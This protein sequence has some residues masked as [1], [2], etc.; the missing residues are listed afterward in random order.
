MDHFTE[1]R[2]KHAEEVISYLPDTI[3][4]A[5]N[6]NNALNKD[7]IRELRQTI[8]SMRVTKEGRPQ[9]AYRKFI[10]LGNKLLKIAFAHVREKGLPLCEGGPGCNACCRRM[11]IITSKLEEDV[12]TR[13]IKKMSTDERRILVKG[14][15]RNEKIMRGVFLAYGVKGAD[16]P[17]NVI[18][19]VCL[20]F[21]EV[22]G[23]CPALG[24]TGRCLIYPVRP[25]ICRTYRVLGEECRPL[26]R[27]NVTR[28]PDIDATMLSLL[29][30]NRGKT[31]TTLFPVIRESLRPPRP[32]LAIV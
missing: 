27:L 31:K 6:F 16:L 21:A 17:T 24:P 22:G 1:T 25:W 30:R 12:I 29:E 32:I 23:F 26:I 13:A 9:Q 20:T 8:K 2:V 3:Y 18:D 4:T 28:F 7:Q 5:A 11:V 15:D 10:K 14:L 19:P